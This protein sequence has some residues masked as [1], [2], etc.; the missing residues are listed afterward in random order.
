MPNATITTLMV[1]LQ[2]AGIVP[3]LLKGSDL[4][5]GKRQQIGL[6]VG[7]DG[8]A[9]T[10]V[11]DAVQIVHAQR[12]IVTKGNGAGDWLRRADRDQ[13]PTTDSKVL[14]I[15]PADIRKNAKSLGRN[16][17]KVLR[18]EH[19]HDQSVTGWDWIEA[20]G[21]GPVWGDLK[22]RPSTGRTCD[23]CDKGIAC[24]GRTALGRN[25]TWTVGHTHN[26]LV[27]CGEAQPAWKGRMS[28]KA[29][30][31][32]EAKAKAEAEAKAKAAAKAAK[33]K[34]T[35]ERNAAKKAAEAAEGK[36]A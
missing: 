32:R 14:V 4:P 7:S 20:D 21:Y 27:T 35:R 12:F 22:A 9:V 36:T 15:L 17:A 23:H 33:A 13:T 31:E 2:T 28:A 5:A 3:T 25:T 1:T 6:L 26:D 11:E 29:I 16:I 24:K 19:R 30:A 8:K 34:A 10:K 18:C